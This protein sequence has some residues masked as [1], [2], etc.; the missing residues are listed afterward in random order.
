M[1]T[2]TGT[3]CHQ[4]S[5]MRSRRQPVQQGLLGK[6]LHEVPC[7]SIHAAANPEYFD[8]RGNLPQVEGWSRQ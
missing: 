6:C 4:G 3:S 1:K 2:E 5:V 8:S 7:V